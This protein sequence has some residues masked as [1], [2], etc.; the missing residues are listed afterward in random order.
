MYIVDSKTMHRL[1]EQLIK[2][3]RVSSLDLMKRAASGVKDYIDEHHTKLVRILIVC[4]VGN[5]GGDG[6][7]LASLLKEDGYVNVT[8]FTLANENQLTSDARFY[9]LRCAQLNIPCFHQLH[10]LEG[11][12]KNSEQC[13]D[14]LFGTGLSR[15]IH[16]DYAQVIHQIN[17]SKLP[18]ISIDMPSGIHSDTGACMGC[19]IHA[20][21]TIS[22]ACYKQGQL[23]GEGRRYCGHLKI[24][25]IGIPHEMIANEEH[26]I[27]LTE[28]KT[29]Q[30]LPKRFEQSHK[31]SYGKVL[32]IGGSRS[33][34]GAITLCAKAMLRSGVGTLTLF[35][36]K[37]IGM[38]LAMKLEECMLIEADDENGM[39]AQ[40]ALS[41]L[42]EKIG[43]YDLIV[44]GNGMGRTKASEALVAYVLQQ[45]IPC[46]LDAD[47]LWSCAK[48][49]ELIKRRQAPLIVTPHPKEFSYLTSKSTAEIK[50]DPFKAV[51]E[52]TSCYPNV[53]LVYKDYVSIIATD[54]K[55]YVNC[56]GNNALAKGGSGD[57]LCGIIS[58]LYAQS[59]QAIEAAG[60][61][62]YVHAKCA[63]ELLQV[64]DANSILPS[65]VIFTLS[66]VYKALR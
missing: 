12:L 19:A 17:A 10:E 24:V 37:S 25:D 45:D 1:D 48:Y 22:F 4:G 63:D 21:V 66:K 18:C 23:L 5:N 61:G 65:D 56:I 34:H 44:I 9:A 26:A 14:A 40:G 64:E 50:A 42:K 20:D 53:T 27:L 32:A 6:F 57:V 35:V 47:A 58:G 39:F 36:P 55:C 28:D 54:K 33:M 15:G 3:Q 8:L 62:V 49:R 51:R 41:L 13:V 38:L 59:K 29:R 30:L 11:L 52:F 46:I 16:G 7:A 60:A 2:Q 31:G 43:D